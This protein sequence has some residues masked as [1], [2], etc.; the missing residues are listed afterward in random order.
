MH[1]FF[2]MRALYMFEWIFFASIKKNLFLKMHI[3]M[4]FLRM[5]IRCTKF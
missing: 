5:H 3:W 4:K 2:K 1:D